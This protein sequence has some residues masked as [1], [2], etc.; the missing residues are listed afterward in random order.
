MMEKTIR[1]NE[2]NDL[3]YRTGLDDSE[4]K[5]K[6]KDNDVVTESTTSESENKIE[7][8]TE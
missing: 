8:F 6:K 7:Y 3:K 1:A 5:K 2:D 4:D